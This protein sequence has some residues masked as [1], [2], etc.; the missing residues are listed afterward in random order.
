MRSLTIKKKS[1]SYLFL[2]VLLFGAIFLRYVLYVDF[3]RPILLIIFTMLALRANKEELLAMSACCIPLHTSMN[4]HYGIIA[5]IL[6]YLIKYGKQMKFGVGFLPLIFLWV[7]ELIHCFVYNYSIKE[8]FAFVL[9][10]IMTLIVMYSPIGEIHYERIMRTLSVCTL[11]MCFILICKLYLSFG[12]LQTLIVNMHR[13]GISVDEVDMYTEAYFNP[14]ALGYFCL[15]STTGLMQTF[16]SGRRKKTDLVFAF[17]L[18]LFGGLTLSRTFM[19]CFVA[20]CV[21]FF[22]T[23]EGGISSKVKHLIKFSF[24][25][26]GVL[27]VLYIVSPEFLENIVGRWQEKDITAGRTDLFAM[28]NK[29]IIHSAESLFFGTGLGN[30]HAFANA[31]FGVSNIHSSHN[32]FQEILIAWGIPGAILCMMFL[33]CIIKRS[34]KVLSSQKLMNYI[35]LLLLLLKVQAG[36]L[37]TSFYTLLMFMLAYLSLVYDFNKTN[38]KE[39]KQNNRV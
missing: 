18:I 14:N 20:M 4:I 11:F 23:T 8:S 35:P 5:C 25:F 36:Q 24:V 19:V 32:G 1:I 29:Y 21:L 31:Y 34:K 39:E 17:L 9:P 30:M 7:W 6:V 10:C 26:I 12:N 27:L 15:L 28:Y 2:W 38:G 3:P 16:M 37:I 13:L 22:F 33:Y